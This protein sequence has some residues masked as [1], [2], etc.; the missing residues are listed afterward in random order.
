[1]RYLGLAAFLLSGMFFIAALAQHWSAIEPLLGDGRLLL[2][3]GPLAILGQLGFVLSATAFHSLLQGM[4]QP[5]RFSSALGIL[6]VSQ[7]TKYLP[8]NVVHHVGRVMMSRNAGLAPAPVSMAI[9]IELAGSA[10]AATLVAVAFAVVRGGELPELYGLARL[11]PGAAMLPALL[12]GALVLAVAFAA[13]KCPEYLRALTAPRPADLAVALGCYLLNVGL[14]GAIFTA[15]VFQIAPQA[16]ADYL[17][18]TAAV[19]AAWTIGLITPGAPGGLGVREAVLLALVSPVSGTEVA[20]LAGLS[21][22]VVTTL[23][24][25]LGFGLGLGL[26]RLAHA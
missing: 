18:L 10:L 12:I 22:R 19:A 15:I 3:L 26:R 5:S 20:L 24:D 17:L 8:G 21:L 2:L 14:M 13:W 9:F 16:G 6:M 7:F 11:S 23:T 1:L 25:A 4:G